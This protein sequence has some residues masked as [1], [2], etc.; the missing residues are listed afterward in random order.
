MVGN[1]NIFALGL[2]AL[3]AMTAPAMAAGKDTYAVLHAAEP[4]IADGSGRIYF[5]RDSSIMG[6]LLQPE[7][8]INGEDTGGD[9]RSGDY[10]YIDR[11]AGTYEIT[12]TTEKKEAATITVTAGQ[13]TYVKTDVSMGFFAGHVS[14]SVIAPETAVKEIADCDYRAP[15]QVAPA[16]PAPAPAPATAP[17]PAPAPAAPAATPAETPAP[18]SH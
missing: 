17:A 5:Y 7:I 8:K 14:P 2:F 12:T 15:K 4:A 9:S 3:V 13:A 6:A 1:R 16:T 18:A 10:F 11:P